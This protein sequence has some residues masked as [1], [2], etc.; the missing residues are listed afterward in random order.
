M[1]QTHASQ[2]EFLDVSLASFVLLQAVQRC[3]LPHLFTHTLAGGG[4]VVRIEGGVNCRVQ[5]D[6]EV[7]HL[8]L[9]DAEATK[10][11]LV[12]EIGQLRLS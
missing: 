10:N 1:C 5:E 2:K 11:P 3:N 7:P 4:V 8:K 6:A 12:D 9:Q